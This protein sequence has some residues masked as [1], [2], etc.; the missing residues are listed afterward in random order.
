MLLNSLWKY[1]YYF[2]ENALG[3]YSLKNTLLLAM[4][5]TV[6]IIYKILNDVSIIEVIKL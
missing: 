2:N 1:Y 3:I 5:I 6:I 4:T